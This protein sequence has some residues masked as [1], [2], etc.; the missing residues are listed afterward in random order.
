M[1]ESIHISILYGLVLFSS[2]LSSHYSVLGVAANSSQQQIKDAYLALC[3]RVSTLKHNSPVKL[4]LRIA[5]HCTGAFE[6]YQISAVS[7]YAYLVQNIWVL[8]CCH[9]LLSKNFF[10]H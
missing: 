8:N 10:L 6:N 2:R 7:L 9:N 3:K 1:C 4:R 5:I